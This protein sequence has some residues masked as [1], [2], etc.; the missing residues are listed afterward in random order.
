MDLETA[1]LQT[2]A[3]APADDTSRLVYADWL[4][5]QGHAQ[6]ARFIREQ[7]APGTQEPHIADPGLIAWEE[8]L[9]RLGSGAFGAAFPTR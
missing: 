9:P 6:R 4:D 5:D 3:A 8:V 1:F 2:I 7:C